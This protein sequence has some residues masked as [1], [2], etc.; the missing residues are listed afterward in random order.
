MASSFGYEAEQYT[1]SRAIGDI[2]ANQ[3]NDASD[4]IV[5]SPGE[6]CRTEFADV[7]GVSEPPGQVP[8][9][10][11]RVTDL[12]YQGTVTDEIRY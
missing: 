12:S 8:S 5:V 1:M 7:V 4:G 3:M 10:P 2:L 6:S 9:Q 11:A